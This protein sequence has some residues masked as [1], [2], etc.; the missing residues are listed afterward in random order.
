MT[1]SATTHQQREQVATSSGND[2]RAVIHRSAFVH[3]DAKLGPGVV[4]G[5]FC[6]VGSETELGA[7]S[8]LISHVVIAG[9]TTIGPRA[10]I[11][12]FASIGHHPRGQEASRRA[13]GL[14]IGADSI[15]REGVTVLPGGSDEQDSSKTTAL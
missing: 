15:I 13:G 2:H 14:V 8:Q 6:H 5:P 12:P 9:R 1:S 4:I 11:F 10:R 3:P 7:G